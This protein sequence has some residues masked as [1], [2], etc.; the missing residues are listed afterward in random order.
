MQP[1]LAWNFY[2]N[3]DDLEVRAPPAFASQVLAGIKG[4]SH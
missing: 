1:W 2:V 3:Q 4:I